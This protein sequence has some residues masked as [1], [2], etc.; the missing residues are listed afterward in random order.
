MHEI[1]DLSEARRE[2]DRIDGELVKLLVRRLDA[3]AAVAAAKRASGKA[4]NDP[5]REREILSRIGAEVP[6]EYE[7][8]AHLIFSTLFAVSKRR[9]RE[10]FGASEGNAPK[11]W[12]VAVVGLGLIGGSFEKAS[13]KAGYDVVGL[14]HG[15]STGFEDANLI[16]VCLPP[17]A[18]A[19]W[20]KSHCASFADGAVVV[21]IA[22]VKGGIMADVAKIEKSGWTFVG[23]H[24][25]AG[26]EV[27]GY[28]NSLAD[29]FVGASMVLVP[30]EGEKCSES[31]KA[32]FRSIGFERVIETTAAKHDALI[33]YTSQLCHVIATAY[34]RDSMLP[35]TS[36]FTAGSFAD[37]TR[38]AT[39]NPAIWSELFMSNRSALLDSL[40][41]FIAHLKEFRSALE[42]NDGAAIADIIESGAEA[43]R[44]ETCSDRA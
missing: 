21:D 29:L 28:E 40:D 42:S 37:M 6:P 27:S 10:I 44:G 35:E 38:I 1:S 41:G 43:K 25:M 15:D 36:G 14:H 12:K 33:A 11:D 24:P 20:I 8:A 30:E 17:G 5:K 23:G 32:F 39:Q 22:G 4:V 19:P 3:V 18:V 13:K 7:S 16:L 2:I 9:Q 26:R 34:A 31:L